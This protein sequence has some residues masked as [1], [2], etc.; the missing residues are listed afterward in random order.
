MCYPFT[1]ATLDFVLL[2]IPWFLALVSIS[3]VEYDGFR[4]GA[5]AHREPPLPDGFGSLSVHPSGSS[6][7][8][9]A[10]SNVLAGMGS[11]LEWSSLVGSQSDISLPSDEMSDGELSLAFNTDLEAADPEGEQRRL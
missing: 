7:L 10:H 9:L 8:S 11:G 4:I 3:A 5:L 6:Q 2:R 1:G